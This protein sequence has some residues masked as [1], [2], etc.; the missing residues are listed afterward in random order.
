M[1][2]GISHTE[3]GGLF[4]IGRR[5]IVGILKGVLNAGESESHERGI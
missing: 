4:Q 1:G 5:K 2:C 3:R